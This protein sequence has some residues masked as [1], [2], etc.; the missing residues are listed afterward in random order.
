M[1]NTQPTTVTTTAQPIIITV[2]NTYSLFSFTN[3][4]I[5]CTGEHKSILETILTPVWGWIKTLLGIGILKF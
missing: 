3:Q 1:K 4:T 2:N 5:G